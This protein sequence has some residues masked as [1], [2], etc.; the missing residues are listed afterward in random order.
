MNVE[1]GATGV[2]GV[3][4]RICLDEVFIVA[5]TYPASTFCAHNPDS[6]CLVQFKGA[7]DGNNPL[8]YLQLV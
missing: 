3:D 5:N 4:S 7:A 8:S 1:Q 6:N 2:A